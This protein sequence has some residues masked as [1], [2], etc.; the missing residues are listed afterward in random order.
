[1]RSRLA[2]IIL[3]VSG[4]GS[5]C[6]AEFK[7]WGLRFFLLLTDP[8]APGIDGNQSTSIVFHVRMQVILRPQHF[9][10]GCGERLNNEI[11]DAMIG[12]EAQRHHAV[13]SNS[14]RSRA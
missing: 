3:Y 5:K 2:L 9:V 7:F 8:D 1:M 14:A 6:G 13:T 10:T 12:E 11:G 4:E